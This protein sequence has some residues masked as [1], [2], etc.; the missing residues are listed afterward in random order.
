MEFTSQYPREG[1]L[2]IELYKLEE[3]VDG[4]Y[5]WENI[6]SLSSHTFQFEIS[7]KINSY[8]LND[9]QAGPLCVRAFLDMNNNEKL[10]RSTMGL[11]KE[12]VGFANNPAL[13][14]G[15]PE[16]DAGC[17]VLAETNNLQQ[18]KLREKKPKKQ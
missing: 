9:L 16:P 7:D 17:F 2:Y 8:T 4:E 12:P 5:L 6:K 14:F 10:D 11:P 3:P 18:I 1:Q 13:M 15:E